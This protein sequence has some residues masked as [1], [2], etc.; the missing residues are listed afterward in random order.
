MTLQALW[1]GNESSQTDQMDLVERLRTGELAA[2]GDAYD[3]H[4]EQVRRF[5]RRLVGDESAAED[6]VQETFLTLP[7]A[8]QRFEGRSSLRTF[9]VSIAA[10]H[11]RHHVRAASRR[12]AA[13][14][15]AAHEDVAPGHSLA[16]A[17]PEQELQR[18]QMA[19]LLN[20]CLDQLS[21]DHRLVFILC[22]VEDYTS[23]KASEVLEVP[24]GTVRT[25]L[26]HAKKKLRTLLE[27][28][29]AR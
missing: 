4:H 8:V 20:R 28:E 12:R 17:N 7:R 9:L 24:E 25:R 27:K 11:S 2:V 29:G 1:S 6:L 14:D 16:S 26:M 3:L 10:N 22:E 19:A 5:A 13:M 21:H 18:R 23:T 15:K